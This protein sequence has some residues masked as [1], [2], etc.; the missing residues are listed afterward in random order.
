MPLATA[1]RRA[2]DPGPVLRRPL[3]HCP[4]GGR[5]RQ[6][7]ESPVQRCTVVAERDAQLDRVAELL[8]AATA[9]RQGQ[10]APFSGERRRATPSKTVLTT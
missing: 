7:H 2:T 6:R 10:A 8:N 1:L 4:L 9:Q 5:P 3:R